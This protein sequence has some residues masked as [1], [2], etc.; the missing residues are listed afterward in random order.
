MKTFQT[1]IV[2][3]T[4]FACTSSLLAQV[5]ATQRAGFGLPAVSSSTQTRPRAWVGRSL[6]PGGLAGT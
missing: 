3:L 6:I 4:L 5:L 1:G 2:A